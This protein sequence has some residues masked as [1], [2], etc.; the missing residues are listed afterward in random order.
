MSST[1]AVIDSRG[2]ALSRVIGLLYAN[3]A[4]SLVIAVLTF[5]SWHNVID[6]EMAHLPGGAPADPV[7][8]RHSLTLSTWITPVVVL[9]VSLVYLRIAA[10]LRRGHRR[11]WIRVLVIAI[12]GIVGL[13]YPTLSGQYP[14][15]MRIGHA[16][17]ELVLLALLVAATRPTVRARFGRS[18]TG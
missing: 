8:E 5:A 1:A 3:L 2:A 12:A 9:A 15:W 4:V 10:R 7:A 13:A 16:V 6:Y 17:Q 18:Q 14:A 11:T